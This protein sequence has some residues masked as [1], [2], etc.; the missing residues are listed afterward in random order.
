[1]M[2]QK[3]KEVTNRSIDPDNL[4]ETHLSIQ[5]SLGGF[6]FCIIDKSYDLVQKVV[7]H[8]FIDSSPSP[9]KLLERVK[10]VFKKEKLLQYKYGS[11]NVSHV[12]ELSSLVP[13][14]LFDEDNLKD[15]IRFSSKTYDNDYIVYDEFEN[16]D[17]VN[18]YI[19]FVNVNNFFLER[20]GSFEY[21]HFSTVFISNLLSTYKFSE[22][23]HLFVHLDKNRMFL[24]AIS[25]NK[26]QIYNSFS[27]QTKEDFLYYILFT[28][29]QLNMNPETFELV[30]SGLVRKEDKLFSLAYRYIKKVSLL[31]NRFKY[32]F[33]PGITEETKR[34]HMA[35]L[36]QY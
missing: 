17:M 29:E 36:N 31:E 13:K 9:E 11:T 24:V 30:L 16:Q 22:H 34:Q 8:S 19:P 21:K 18:V 14:S 25:Q 2:D 28:A 5:L 32:N 26:L 27:F 12:N 6:S 15:Y 4:Y 7:H 23:P 20:F 35:L 33:E 1:M 10:D 3:K